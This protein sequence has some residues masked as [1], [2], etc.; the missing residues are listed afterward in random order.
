MIVKWQF[1]CF[2]LVPFSSGLTRSCSWSWVALLAPLNSLSGSVKASMFFQRL[3]RNLIISLYWAFNYCLVLPE[4]D[5]RA[6]LHFASSLAAMLRICREMKCM[7]AFS[8]RT[9]SFSMY[10][11]H[12]FVKSKYQMLTYSSYVS[13]ADS[14]EFSIFW[15]W[16]LTWPRWR[17]AVIFGISEIQINDITVYDMSVTKKLAKSCLYFVI[18]SKIKWLRHKI[19]CVSH[20]RST[21]KCIT[22]KK[23]FSETESQNLDLNLW[24]EKH[25]I[26]IQILFIHFWWQMCEY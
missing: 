14:V 9:L 10:S 11:V 20:W 3:I 19:S 1:C 8:V 4:A 2:I 12:F 18:P 22:L 26:L 23:H 7:Q 25:H 17:S 24:E 6:S 16:I 15:N 5:S 13:D 21:S